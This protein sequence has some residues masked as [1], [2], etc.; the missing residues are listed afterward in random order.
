MVRLKNTRKKDTLHAP[1]QGSVCRIAGRSHCVTDKGHHGKPRVNCP[2]AHSI[3]TQK[4]ERPI[5][6]RSLAPKPPLAARGINFAAKR[7]QE[8][9]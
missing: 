7:N 1:V 5:I 6:V 2:L 3:E 9:L 4:A 8:R